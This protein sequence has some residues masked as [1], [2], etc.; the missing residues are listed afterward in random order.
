MA[1]TAPGVNVVVNANASNPNNAVQTANWFVLGV[2]A[3]PAGVVVPINSMTD[4]VK[5]FGYIPSATSTS[6]S[7]NATGRYKF[8]NVDSTLL[9][10][11]LDVFFREG[12]IN[13]YVSRVNA[14]SSVAAT[15]GTLGSAFTLT[16]LGGGTWANSASGTGVD[17][18]ILSVTFISSGLYSASI[19]YNG[20]T[21]ASISGLTGST[22]IINWINSLPGYQAMCTAASS[23]ASGTLPSSGTTSYYFT[24]GTDV[25]V[26]GTDTAAALSAI[27][28]IYGPGQVSYPGAT[29]NATWVAITNHCLANN[30]V[31]ILDAA[32]VSTYTPGTTATSIVTAVNTSISGAT[33]QSYAAAF[34]PWLIVPGWTST[35]TAVTGSVLPRVVPPSALVAANIAVNDQTNDC[36]VPAAGVKGG[37][38]S[39]VTGLSVY[40][41]DADRATLNTANVNVI[42][43][44][45]S[46]NQIALYGYRSLATDPNW[47]FLNNVRFRM[48]VI[49][50]FD[51]I[52]EPFVFQE[53]DAKGQIFAKLNGALAGQCSAYWTRQSIYGVN[54]ADAYQVNT[55]TQ[56]NTPATI[57]AGQ[58]NA[59]V[60]LRMSPYGELVTVNVNKY[61]V[62]A[63]LPSFT[64]A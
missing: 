40:F 10:D 46:L 23:S 18:L 11:S 22:D 49:R 41:T 8:T 64:N 32:N 63:S 28:S 6:T 16:A 52:A 56:V 24:G 38:A 21:T 47:Y 25:A 5:Y 60:N 26:A 31:A 17:G 45:P 55:G 2:A 29:D 36:N 34:T 37:S 43:Q 4:F 62:S 20:F 15:T 44:V 48:Q 3:G 58:I 59:V 61:L 9:F 19:S 12:G 14:S 42:R 7:A 13:A 50:D 27:T 57:A 30:R 1:T 39:Y 53:I 35:S 51:A 33:D 54:T